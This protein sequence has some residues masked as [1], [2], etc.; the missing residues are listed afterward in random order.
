ML[1]DTRLLMS[2]PDLSGVKVTG[3]AFD[4]TMKEMERGFDVTM[5]NWKDRSDGMVK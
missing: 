5:K 2:T 4:L 3:G 1:Y